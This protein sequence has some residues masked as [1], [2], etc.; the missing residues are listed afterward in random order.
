[1]PRGRAGL[2]S[3][4]E[5]LRCGLVHPLFP[6]WIPGMQLSLRTSLIKCDSIFAS[7]FHTAMN[8]CVP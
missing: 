8:M 7:L 3:L 6:G 2:T 5:I 1:M 4:D